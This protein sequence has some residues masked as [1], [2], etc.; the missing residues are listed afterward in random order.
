[1]NRIFKYLFTGLCLATV[2]VG[3][4]SRTW[5][6]STAE[7]AVVISIASLDKQMV[8]IEH[9]LTASGFPQ[10][11][12]MVQSPVKQYSKGIN[13]KK[14]VGV[15]LFLNEEKEIPDVLAFIPV[16]NLDDVLDNVAGFVQVDEE[17]DDVTISMDN[18]T[19]LFIRKKG[20][21]ALITNDEAVFALA[22]SNPEATLDELPAKYNF[23]AKVFGSRIPPALRQQ[24]MDTMRDGYE[25]QM[26]MLGENTL[27]AD[28]QEMNWKQFERALNDMGTVTM[29]MATNKDEKNIVLDFEILAES[30]SEMAKR[31]NESSLKEGSQFKGFL[32]KD[33][34]MTAHVYSGIAPEDVEQS[35]KMLDKIPEMVREQLEDEDLSDEEIEMMEKVA[36]GFGKIV[37]DTLAQGKMDGG[38]VLMGEDEGLNFAAGF[39]VANPK[40]LENLVKQVVPQIEQS[41]G[42]RV[43]VELNSGSYKDVTFHR[44]TIEMPDDS[45]EAINLLGEQAQILV[46]IGNK[47]VYF[48]FGS[49]PLDLVKKS[50]DDAGPS[51][52]QPAFQ[53]NMFMAPMM[54]IVSRASSE[55]P[56]PKRM[57]K[58]L[59]E[60]GADRIRL[61]TEYIPNGYRGRLEIQDGVLSMIKVAADGFS[62]GMEDE[63]WED[64]DF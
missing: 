11:K 57:A 34:A 10:F 27:Q 16:T 61:T 1:V 12:F 28:L 2:A 25:Q 19:Q 48:A 26:Q 15:L 38:A 41:A 5:A 22:P 35:Q 39:A 64:E 46:G 56:M 17:G 63:D 50:M 36:S 23:S 31:F 40:E 20:E 59:A 21:V 53:M 29:G 6:Q 37:A 49:N 60:T 58:K 51:E 52:P 13:T 45:E 14:P 42:S 32:M 7:P 8:M 54:K 30:N 3:A 55:D 44:F 18:G 9:L 43:Q 47:S 24:W 33:A 62:G 4:P